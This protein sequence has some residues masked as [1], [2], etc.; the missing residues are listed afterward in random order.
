MAIKPK[1]I[2]MSRRARVKFRIRSK[3]SGTDAKP[4]ISVFKSNKHTY[5]QVISD[6]ANATLI[7]A[8]TRE[9]EVIKKIG[10]IDAEGLHSTVKSAKG[11]LAAKAVGIV[12][13]ERC[14]AKNISSVLFDRNGFVYHGRIKA[15][16][17]GARQAG[18]VF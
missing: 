13:G 10:S 17:E 15:L 3:L 11:L 4:R 16:A 14:K 8:S 5:A 1:Q 2:K 9:K 12:L 6:D 18:L 7:S